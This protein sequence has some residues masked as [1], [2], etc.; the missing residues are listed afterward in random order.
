LEMGRG[1]GGGAVSPHISLPT[2]ATD[3]WPTFL[4][5]NARDSASAETFFTTAN[6]PTLTKLW[7]YQTGGGIAAEPTIV[8]DIVY[9]GSWDGSMYAINGATGAL[10]WK[11]FLGQTTTPNCV[12]STIG[13]TSAATVLNGIVYVGG[14]DSY[15]YALDATSGAILWK[16]YT[17]DNSITGGYYNWSSPLIYNGYAYIGLA[18]NCDNP[19]AQGKLMQVDLTS[20]SVVNTLDLVP[21]GQ[22]GGGIWTTPAVDAATNT[23]YVTTGTKNQTTQQY[24]QAIIAIDATSLAVKNYWDLPDA[25]A[26]VDSDWGAS[27][28]L[29]DTPAG[30]HLAVASNKDGYLYAFDRTNLAAGPLWRQTIS[31]GGT[32]PTDGDGSISTVAVAG[33]TIFAAGGNT[34]I[35]GVGYAG[36]V[37]ALDASGNILWQHGAAGP[38]VPAVTTVNGLVIDEAGSTI[39][40]LDASSGQR[41][42]SY[43]TGGPIYAAASVSHGTIFTGSVDGNVYALALGTPITPPADTN[44]PSGWICQDIGAASPAGS[45]SATGSSWTIT[46]SGAGLSANGADAA[47]LDAQTTTGDT[48]IT[49]QLSST[50]AGTAGLMAR[51]SNDPGS[52]FYAVVATSA[53]S[54]TVEY[55]TRF[56]GAI[57]TANQ[58]AIPAGAWLRL[59]RSGDTFRAAT[60]PD[61]ANWTL[62]PGATATLMLPATMLTGMV[63]ASGS[64]SFASVAVGAPGTIPLPPASPSPCPT[65]WTCQDIGDPLVTGD[66][67]L[68]GG[69][70]TIK[71]AGNG[72]NGYGDQFHY[73]WQSIGGDATLSARVTAQTNTSGNAKAGIMLRQSS[74]AGAA[75][76]GM[77][78]TPSNGLAITWRTTNGLRVSVQALTGTAPIYMQIQRSGNTF[79]AWTSPDGVNWTYVP[80]S[81]QVLNTSGGMLAG[82][83]LTSNNATTLGSATIDSISLAQSAPPPPTICPTGWNC[84]DIGTPHPAGS[85]SLNGT[86]WTVIAG[87]NDIYATSDTFRYIWQTLPGDGSFSARVT[88]QSNTNDYAKAGVMIRASSD[89]AAAYYGMFLTPGH[90]IL[91][92]YRTATSQFAGQATT[93]AGTAPVF[94][95]VGRSGNTFTAYT[96]PDGSTWTVVAG[97]SVTINMPTNALAGMAVTSHNSSELGTVTFDK[98]ILLGGCPGAWTCADIG[99]PAVT[100]GN[101]LANGT[102]NITAGGTDIWGTSDQFHYI[103]QTQTGDGNISAQVTSQVNSDTN[104]KA[105][106]MFRNTVDPASAYYA[107]YVTPGSG[108]TVQYRAAY[109]ANSG[110]AATLTGTV[111]AWLKI[112]RAVNTFTAYTSSDGTN[113]TLVPGSTMTITMNATLL[114]GMAVTAHSATL[115]G[116]ASFA[117]VSLTAPPPPNCPAPWTCG[118]IGTPPIAGSQSLSNG[119]WT[120]QGNGKDIWGTS[121]QFHYVYQSVTGD[122]TLIGQITS[123]ANTDQNAKA[124]LMFRQ[125]T[126]PAAPFYAVYIT[127]GSGITVQ[128][129]V[130]QGAYT[131]QAATLT[132]SVPQWFEINRSG[133]VFTAY[134]S[135]DGTTWTLIPNSTKTIGISG[136]FLLGMAVTSHQVA[137]LGSATFASV[138]LTTPAPPTCPTA[139]T[140]TDIG[141][142]TLAGSQSVN[143]ATWTVTGGGN[144]IWTNPDQFH[145]V[146]QSVATDTTLSA[147]LTAQTNTS[148]WA[149]AGLMARGSTDPGAPFYAV[150]I[151]PG[152]GIVVQYR[153][154]QGAGGSSAGNLPTGTLPVYLRVMRAGTTFTAYTSLDGTTWTLIPNSSRTLTNLSGTLL[155]G[156]A[157]TAHNGSKL[158]TLT[159]DTVALGTGSST[160]PQRH[161]HAPYRAWLRREG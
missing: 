132:G 71:G 157:V 31:I 82:L 94:L 93:L 85:Q 68:S 155:W 3:D 125:T 64:A 7:S 138:S 114:V 109:G 159:L 53:T 136:G 43:T 121:D 5:D 21:T 57:T 89:P 49:A 56:G 15:W 28:A 22:V 17:G 103:W 151:T 112:V 29:L 16:V 78:L 96:S 23:I 38:V 126:D 36:S 30:Q 104:A 73:V 88:S 4:H 50:A 106:L 105:G 102:W 18:S 34:S 100:G 69:V 130:T 152:N 54:L 120:I 10:V 137:T 107:I 75:F 91:I 108:I 116:G 160:A 19:L 111:P 135:P 14:G 134:T 25:D 12:P 67:S 141:S 65:N 95:R 128:Y 44:C 101:Q 148:A 147:H 13:I 32:S 20:H 110:Q 80:G 33:S 113:W 142:P 41:L 79:T 154:A 59:I 6:A 143:G 35:N 51:Q 63:V 62:V 52:P 60:A 47:R 129:R 58:I 83:A 145:Y 26:V 1:S 158:S 117:N 99:T 115:T 8:N 156:V 87:G 118:D 9:V 24:A 39:E 124:G 70:W 122:G 81:N 127:P 66:Q 146:Y 42:Y 133:N 140:C 72:I 40:V 27:P 149:K 86:V 74:D 153:N 37:R 46:S 150:Y 77:F 61:G 76:Y 55:R 144:D 131:G 2:T 139:W 161:P 98:V 119:I 92:Q 84:A 90:G 97:S 11:T 123:Q 45:E 48:Q